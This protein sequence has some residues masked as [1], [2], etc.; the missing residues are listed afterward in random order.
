M[1]RAKT[2]LPGQENRGV[3]GGDPGGEGQGLQR[4]RVLRHHAGRGH[5]PRHDSLQLLGQHLGREWLHQ[6]VGR[7]GHH[8]IHGVLDAA[9]GGDHQHRQL[10]Q[11]IADAGEEGGAVHRLHLVI[12]HD[13]GNR[14]AREH[15]QGLGP[16]GGDAYLEAGQ[17]QRLGQGLAQALVVFHE[18]DRFGSHA[19]AFL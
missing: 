5:L 4:H 7:A 15:L 12:G 19:A 3:R 11:A 16:F 6:I 8:G 13:G 9:V 14:G 10:R 18:E 1:K 17:S 2:A